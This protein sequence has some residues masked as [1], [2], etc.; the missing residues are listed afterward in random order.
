MKRYL[1]I[2]CL[3]MFTINGQA[4]AIRASAP[5]G[6]SLTIYDTGIAMVRERRMITFAQGVNTVLLEDMPSSLNVATINFSPP[7]SVMGVYLLDLQ[8]HYDAGNLQH[9]LSRYKQKQ[10][11]ITLADKVFTG[12]LLGINE[13]NRTIESLVLSMNDETVKFLQWADVQA[14]SFPDATDTLFLTPTLVWRVDSKKDRIQNVRMNYAMGGIEWRA[15]YELLLNEEQD[16]GLFTGRIGILNHTD[17]HF[18]Q[19]RIRL[20]STE[21]GIAEEAQSGS[22]SGRGNHEQ[23]QFRYGYSLVSSALQFDGLAPIFTH[24]LKQPLTLNEHD[25]KWVNYVS[26]DRL[27]IEKVY[28]YD[29]VV[30]DR[31]QRKR[32]NDWNYGTESSS[33]VDI[34]LTFNNDSSAGLGEPMAPGRFRLYQRTEHGAI[35]LQGETHLSAIAAGLKANV[36]LEPAR[37]LF[38]E[39]ERIA[40]S[41]VVPQHEYEETFEIRL[42]NNLDKDVEIRVVEHLYRWS[43][44]T[45][46]RA[47][48]EYVKTAEDTI[49]FKPLVKAGGS[50]AIRYTVKYQW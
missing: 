11:T 40:Y 12:K 45:I 43:N 30:F 48:S 47:D 42:I 41:E 23:K 5:Q 22:S 9:A 49:E 13:Y 21:K 34:Y 2:L 27:P 4:E 24:T 46:V 50:R 18:N 17:G 33:R 3:L 1:F 20:I 29:G 6:T 25:E 19:A 38:G 39:R 15:E 16:E 26:A 8:L 32:R 14:I 44:F 10:I 37:G 28:V 31:F 36:R 7:A 35:D